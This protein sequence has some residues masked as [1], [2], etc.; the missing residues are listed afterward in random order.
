LTK[1]IKD[2]PS[3]RL[4]LTLEKNGNKRLSQGDEDNNELRVLGAGAMGAKHKLTLATAFLLVMGPATFAAEQGDLLTWGELEAGWRS[5]IVRPPQSPPG[6]GDSL[7]PVGALSDRSNIAKFWEY[8]SLTPGLYLEKLDFGAQTKDGTYFGELRATDIGSNFQKYVV[9]LQKA[10][11]HY[12][13]FTWDQ[14]PHLYSTSAQSIWCG[15]TALVPCSLPNLYTKYGLGGVASSDVGNIPG[16]ASD[17]TANLHTTMLGIRRDSGEVN[18]RWTP[19]HDWDFKL[20]YSHEKREGTQLAAVSTADVGGTALQVPRPISDTTQN[21]D[22]NGEYYGTTPWDGKFNV[23]LGYA[24]SY[25][26]NDFKSFTVQNPFADPTG[27]DTTTGGEGGAFINQVSLMPSNQMHGVTMQGGVDLPGKSRYNGTLSYSTMRQNDEFLPF[28]SNIVGLNAAGIPIPTLPAASLNGRIDTLLSNNVLN[29]PITKELKSTST[30]RYY[31]FANRTPELTFG[32]YI[33][34]DFASAAAVGTAPRRSLS[35]SY[36]KQ[37]ASEELTWLASKSVKLGVSG[38][39]E[40]YDRTRRAVNVTNEWTGKAF[41]DVQISDAALLRSSVQYSERR[42]EN[43]DW[44]NYVMLPAMVGANDQGLR[45]FDLANR[46]RTKATV[47]VDIST[48]ITGLTI[49]PTAGLRFDSYGLNPDTEFGLRKDNELNAGVEVV[50]V[51][52]PGATVMFAYMHENL[53]RNLWSADVV[54]DPTS[55]FDFKIK[56]TVAT[57]MAAANFELIPDQ[58]DW[59]V[60]YTYM[61]D[62]ESYT[63]VLRFDP[64]TVVPSWFGGFPAVKT[65]FYRVDSTLRYKF[66]PDLVAKMGWKGTVYAK[67]GYTWQRNVV[68]NWQQDNVAPYMFGI[69]QAFAGRTILMAST[70]PNYSAQLIKASLALKW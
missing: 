16:L 18:Y 17:I 21:I 34:E 6:W 59:K 28:T 29:V 31:D 1:G 43:Y 49:T 14:I 24:A 33:W 67:L 32:D 48:P 58:L 27:V 51:I 46:N 36:T 4:I 55:R 35:P 12:F 50:Y 66:D 3:K 56:E 30:Y 20:N 65:D 37:N 5:Y 19:S 69:D 8:G 38:G 62:N 25:Y 42:F 54:V 60:S 47:S 7:T 64:T 2:Q 13:M 26:R 70:N 10:G 11:E 68:S 44:V 52:K 40:H 63:E 39:W 53:D 15:T 41:A 9:D 45:T 22:A 23:G 61:H 57:Y